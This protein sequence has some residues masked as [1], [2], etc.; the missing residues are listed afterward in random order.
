MTTG[1]LIFAHTNGVIDYLEL[2]RWCA[3]NVRRHLGIPVALITDTHTAK[4]NLSMFDH[5]IEI[6][7]VTAGNRWFADYQSHAHWF[8]TTRPDAFDLTPWD[9]T[10]LLDADMCINSADYQAL[11]QSGQDILCHRQCR[12]IADLDHVLGDTFGRCAMPMWWATVI[13]FSK[14]PRSRVVFDLMKMVRDNWSHYRDLYGINEV[15]F[16]NDIAL[17]IALNVESGHTLDIASIPWSLLTVLPQHEISLCEQDQ[18][19]LWNLQYVNDQNKLMEVDFTGLDFHAM[20]KAQLEKI[21]LNG[22]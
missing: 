21:A 2:A 11:F 17:S 10:L 1:A 5:V 4:T 13:W 3:K 9:H 6:D 8:N 22:T 20:N 14:T 16:R 15:D 12:S 19:K 18:I 7:P